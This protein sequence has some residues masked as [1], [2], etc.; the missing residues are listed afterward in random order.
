[1]AASPLTRLAHLIQRAD[2]WI[3]AWTGLGTGRDKTTAGTFEPLLRLSDAEL[4]WLYDGDPMAAKVVDTTPQHMLRQGFTVTDKDQGVATAVQT[5]AV[6]LD[7]RG[8]LE[9]GLTWGRCYGGAVVMIGADDL[10]DSSLPLDESRIHSLDFLQVY[11]KRQVF[12]QSYHRDPKHPRF[13]EPSVYRITPTDGRESYVHESRLILCRGAFTSL[14]Q[15]RM[16]NYW[17]Y[18]VLQRPYE[19]L[20]QF[21]ANHKAAENMMTDASQAVLKIKGLFAQIASGDLTQLQTRAQFLDLSR[22][23]ARAVLLDADNNESL[24]YSERSFAGVPDMLDRSALLLAAVSGIPVTLLMGRAPAGLNATGD[25][26]TRGFYDN[27]QVDRELKLRPL[28]ERMIHLIALSLKIQTRPGIEFPPLWQE[29]PKEQAEREKLEAD[30]DQVRITS[31]VL[32]PEEVALARYS[33]DKP[34]RP[35]IDPR[36]RIVPPDMPPEQIPGALPPKAPGP[37]QKAP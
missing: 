22:S 3:N 12:P 35:R 36:T 11:D 9:E 10:Q 4:S 34:R 1:M 23:V 8:K 24:D 20:R 28:L 5:K 17:D 21:W 31:Q 30:T 37:P 33:G 14:T 32:T 18:S 6:A 7:V 2:G 29:T 27:L 15:R 25:A 13:G 16:M 19:V 26:D